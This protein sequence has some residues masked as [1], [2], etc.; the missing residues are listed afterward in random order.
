MPHNKPYDM[1]KRILTILI[2]VLTILCSGQTTQI[3][4]FNNVYLQKE[5]SA[6]KAKYSQTI[7]QN[8]DGSVTTSVKNIK[9]D[10]LISSETYKGNE[11]FGI[12]KY[13]QSNMTSELDYAFE[14]V[15]SDQACNDSIKGLRNYFENNE[16]LIYTAPKIVS[17]EASIYYFIARNTIYPPIARES[18][19][20]GKVYL[21]FTVNKEGAIENIVVKKG[22]H[23]LLDKEAVRVIRLLKFS[24]P[25][26][27][28]GQTQSF[29]VTMPISFKLM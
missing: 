25:A 22:A 28:N 26:T 29:C 17:G 27:L 6:N 12:W 4:Y 7:S 5:V 24:N 18:G 3:K 15:Y 21:T 9:K 20:Q 10:E 2:I 11:P 1:N 19:I 23:I 14:L 16:N 13:R 8:G